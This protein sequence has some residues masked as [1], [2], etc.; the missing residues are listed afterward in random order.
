MRMRA[1]FM[2]VLVAGG[3]MLG[4]C[5]E[6]ATEPPPGMDVETGP[7]DIDEGVP[8][9]PGKVVPGGGSEDDAA[10]TQDETDQDPKPS[11]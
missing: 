11:E 8:G 5:G 6:T 2:A 1:C 3:L 4:G 9:A 7:L 10:D